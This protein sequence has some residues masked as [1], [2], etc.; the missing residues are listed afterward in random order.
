MK[1][2]IT[3]IDPT[4]RQKRFFD[5]AKQVG[6]NSSFHNLHGRKIAIGAVVVIGNYV[7]SEGYNKRKTHPIQ[8][9]FNRKTKYFAPSP[10]IHA[11]IDALIR[12][13][14]HDLDGAEVFVYRDRVQ[15][16]LGNCRPCR[17]CMSALKNAG[18]KHIY[19]TSNDGFYYERI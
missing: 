13:R 16:S 3:K 10:N 19:Y 7:V 1:S 6:D 11:E 14:Q 8:A 5:L 17:S 4:T 12:S 2:Q 9:K 15:D 18:V